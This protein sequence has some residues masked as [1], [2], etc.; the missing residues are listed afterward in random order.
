M[1]PQHF[2]LFMILAAGLL[3]CFLASALVFL[4]A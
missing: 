4:R 1:K 3:A 2:V